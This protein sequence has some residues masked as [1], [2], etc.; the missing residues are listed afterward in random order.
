[1]LKDFDKWLIPHVTQ[2]E[3]EIYKVWV[4]TGK[5][6]KEIGLSYNV[7]ESRICQII[8]KVK[9]LGR[10]YGETQL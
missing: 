2:H 7:S 1:V 9:K 8:G 5:P 3:H 6:M 10:E 4:T